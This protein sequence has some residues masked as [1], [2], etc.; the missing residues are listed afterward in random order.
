MADATYRGSCQCGAVRIE[1]ELDLDG[2]I[3]CNCSRCR[4][5]GVVYAFAPEARFRLVTGEGATTEYLFNKHAIAHRFCATCG[6]EVYAMGALPD[7]TRMAAVNAN[8]LDGVEPRA[9]SPRHVDGA[10]A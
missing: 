4:R 1:A 7:G 6:I 9:L 2:A 10:S 3:T 5:L 8:C